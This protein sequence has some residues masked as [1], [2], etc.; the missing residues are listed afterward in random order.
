MSRKWSGVSA[1]AIWVAAGAAGADPAWVQVEAV[2]TLREAEARAQDWAERLPDVGGFAM[3]SGWYA[4]ALGPFADDDA[5]DARAR[6]LRSGRMIPSDSYVTDGTEYRQQFWPVGAG[7]TGP[8]ISAPA[9]PADPMAAPATAPEPTAPRPTAAPPDAAP[10]LAAPAMPVETMAE[11]RASEARL[12]RDARMDLQRALAW[13]GFY[14]AGIDGAFGRGTRASMAAWQEANGHEPTGVLSTAQRAEVLAAMAREK[15]QLGLRRV[16]EDEAG[17]EIDLP[18]GLVAFDRYDPPFVHYKSADGTGIRV[19]LISR[20]GDQAALRG[21]YEAMQTLEIVPLDGP[22]DLGRTRFDISGQNAEI[23]SVV[24]A[25]LRDGAIKGYALVWPVTADD[26]MVTRARAAMKDSFRALDGRVLDDSLGQPMS[27]SRADLMSGLEVRRPVR[28]RSGVYVDERG[29]VLTTAEAVADCGRVTVDGIDARLGATD[30]DLGLALLEPEA[31]LAPRAVADWH[32]GPVELN[33][34]VAVAGYPYG[35]AVSAPVLTFGT[36]AGPGGL[37]GETGQAR[38][39]LAA[40]EGDAGGPVLDA[41]GAAIGLLLPH[42]EGDRLLP[43][44]LSLTLRAGP[45][46][47]MLSAAGITPA[48]AAPGRAIMAAEDLSR[49]A[50]GMTVL[51]SCWN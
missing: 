42:P 3:R 10:A 43:A 34:E 14:S 22:R 21:L 25:E 33:A 44:D 16:T 48:T 49:R 31:R 7:L 47:Q 35:D 24:H 38:L 2:P 32:V 39:A 20:P 26:R 9:L 27:V 18:M 6:S 40:L 5:A 45:I 30:P 50:A 4:I 11:A 28:A 17:I 29:A 23:A 37:T 51:V 15:A 41:T 13:A 36:M 19:V 1:L 8:R 46:T 12:D